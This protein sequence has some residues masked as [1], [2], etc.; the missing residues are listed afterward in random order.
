M[1]YV[2]VILLSVA[3]I[4]PAAWAQS[5]EQSAPSDLNPGL[6]EI[7]AQMV[8]P[9]TGEPS[10]SEVCITGDEAKLKVPKTKATDDC[11]AT[12]TPSAS[13]EVAYTIQC[14]KLKRST[15][16]KFTYYGNRYERV[17]T[18]NMDAVE[19]KMKYTAKRIGACDSSSRE[20]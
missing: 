6:W 15:T 11:Q 9:M 19:I 5:K 16:A 7:T 1:K 13:N 20:K 8:A 18:T 3:A 14:P 2:F 10:T 17:S 12:E 4:S